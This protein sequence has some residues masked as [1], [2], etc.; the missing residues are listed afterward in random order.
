MNELS[1]ATSRPGSESAYPLA[2]QHACHTFSKTLPSTSTPASIVEAMAYDAAPRAKVR[3][4]QSWC[5]VTRRWPATRP[6]R[7]PVPRR[8]AGPCRAARTVDLPRGNALSCQRRKVA[9][10]PS[11]GTIYRFVA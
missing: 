3:S 5:Y 11:I 1:R 6:I 7:V 10:K 9:S 4:N 2:D 8:R